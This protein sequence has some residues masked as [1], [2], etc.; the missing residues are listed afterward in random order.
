LN[1]GHEVGRLPRGAH[2]SIAPSQMVRTKDDWGMLLF[3][4]QKFW[5]IFCQTVERPDLI[6]DARFVDIPTR[7]RNV[8][9]LTQVLD[10]VFQTRT[11]DAWMAV[12]GGKAPFAPVKDLKDALENPYVAEISMRDV[13]DHPDRPEGLHM[14]AS[15]VK[16]NGRRMPGV[17]APKMGEHNTELL[18]DTGQ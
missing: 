13:V 7:R 18:G 1:E 4:T 3:Q 5:E 14:L 15:P 2:P 17:R 9:E 11:T 10:E 12:L 6:T 8:A 16:V